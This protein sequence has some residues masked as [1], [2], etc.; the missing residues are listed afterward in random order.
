MEKIKIREDLH[1]II[2]MRCLAYITR[3]IIDINAIDCI[4]L[5]LGQDLLLV[6]YLFD[7][8]LDGYMIIRIKDITFIRS[9]DIERFSEFILKKEGI[10]SQIKEPP[11][12]NLES[13]GVVFEELKVLGKNIIIECEDIEDGDFYLGEII[14]VKNN[15]VLLLCFDAVGEWDQEAIEILFK[16]ITSVSFNKRYIITISKYVKTK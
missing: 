1:N 5:I 10:L 3:E 8:Q 6:Q 13:W 2:K 14:K 4:P 16:D 15:S 9:D 12:S 7:F 11:I